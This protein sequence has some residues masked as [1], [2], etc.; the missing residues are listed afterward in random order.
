MESFAGVGGAEC[1]SAGGGL[2]GGGIVAA[3]T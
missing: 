3:A 2:V 1:S